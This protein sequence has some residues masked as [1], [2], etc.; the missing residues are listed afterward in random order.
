MK[1]IAKNN[2]IDQLEHKEENF[3]QE[4]NKSDIPQEWITHCDHPIDKVIGDI[5]KW[6]STRLNLKE[7]CLNMEFDSQIEPLKINEALEDN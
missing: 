7:Y 3:Q 1:G 6:F 4:Q 5:S 2:K